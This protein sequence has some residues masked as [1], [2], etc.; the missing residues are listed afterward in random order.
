MTIFE[1]AR[2]L[3]GTIRL[4]GTTQEELSQKL[5][6]SQSY[7][8]NKLRLLRYPVALQDMI[9]DGGLSERHA[10]TILRLPDEAMQKN[11]INRAIRDSLT[12]QE[13]ETMVDRMLAGAEAAKE[14]DTRGA[15]IRLVSQSIL[16][17]IGVLQA[18]GI[19][20]Q[21]ILQEDERNI[22]LTFSVSK[23]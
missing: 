1:E 17:G 14:K 16:E 2:A 3:Y 9:T 13:T 21:K 11:A 5:G 19:R 12:V 4:C 23:M 15:V 20:S 7:I 6:V 18:A 8:A 10:R 22:L